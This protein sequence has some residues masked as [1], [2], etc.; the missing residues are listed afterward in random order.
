MYI[1]NAPERSYWESEW[2][3]PPTRTAISIGF[4]RDE[5]GP[6]AAARSFY[7]GLPQRFEQII[8]AARPKLAEVWKTW[9]QADLPS[10]IFSAMT[11]GGFCLEDPEARPLHWDVSF[12]TTGDK[13]LGITVPFID[14]TPQEA[15]VDT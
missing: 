1:P 7:L 12:E 8:A 11:I 5:S 13:W 6:T 14:D 10:D 4:P 15:V 9:L 3:F 2:Q